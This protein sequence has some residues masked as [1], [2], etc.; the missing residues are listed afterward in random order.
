MGFIGLDGAAEGSAYGYGDVHGALLFRIPPRQHVEFAL[1]L[2]GRR[3]VSATGAQSW[4]EF[5]LPQRYAP[6]RW[7]A[8]E[9]GLSFDLRPA[10]LLSPDGVFDVRLDAAF[11]FP[12]GPWASIDVGARAYSFQ[13]RVQGGGVL[14]LQLSL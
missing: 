4:F 13:G 10:V 14:G 9:P 3:L 8:L 7:S 1:S 6:F 2:G 12:L 11:V 5:S